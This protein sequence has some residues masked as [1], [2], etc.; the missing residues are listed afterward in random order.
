MDGL[1]SGVR[2][3]RP[4]V[5]RD[6]RRRRTTSSRRSARP[7][8]APPWG[9]CAIT[10]PRGSSSATRDRCCSVHAR[11]LGLMS[12]SRS[13]GGAHAVEALILGVPVFD[14]AFVSCAP[15]GGRTP[16]PAGG[17]TTPRI[18]FGARALGPARGRRGVR[19]AAR[20]FDGRDRGRE[21]TGAG[22][23]VR[24]RGNGARARRRGRGALARETSIEHL[25]LSEGGVR[26][27]AG[28][29]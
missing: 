26:G 21:P 19:G 7:W 15:A 1:A 13:N 11:P 20:L 12:T 8:R 5:L 25:G 3:S 28:C 10:S 17:R 2:R 16:G 24:D 23:A 9:S 27:R 29:G 14:T 6:P 4:H 22:A 18:D